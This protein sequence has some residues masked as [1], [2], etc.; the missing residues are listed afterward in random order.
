MK[1]ILVAI[2]LS[3]I[4]VMLSGCSSTSPYKH[5]VII[6]I[7]QKIWDKA[8]NN[9][10]Q[11]I[12]AEPNNS[13][14]HYWLGIAYAGKGLYV[15]SAE[16]LK[17]SYELDT[18]GVIRGKMGHNEALVFMNAGKKL[19]SKDKNLAMSYFKMASKLEPKNVQTLLSI[20]TIYLQEGKFDSALVYTN[21]S[22]AIDSEKPLPHTY[23][24]TIYDTLGVHRKDSSAIYFGLASSELHKFV[25]LSTDKK[26]GYIKLG[27]FYLDHFRL[28]KT[29]LDTSIIYYKKAIALDSTDIDVWFNLGIAYNN[30]RDYKGA[31]YCFG[32]YL[33]LH[34]EDTDALELYAMAL[35]QN[36]DY[37]DAANAYEKLINFEPN[38]ADYYIIL[39]GIY[40]SL[41]NS[42][43]ANK[44]LKIYKQL[45]NKSN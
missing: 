14:S 29:Y 11:W 9:G 38:T 12:K 30:N 42:K 5:S 40:N 41:H 31:A 8:V 36:K 28:N 45:Q 21:K 6:Y 19:Y 1:K 33:K 4:T 3:A 27:G 18:T 25:E 44:Y 10:M 15:K 43:K 7:Q 13:E 16:Q 22:L 23:L 35:Y 32:K 24:A 17:L 20:A 39:A 26:K 37:K 2:T 34:P